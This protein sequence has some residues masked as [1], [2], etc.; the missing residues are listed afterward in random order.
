MAIL[1]DF[2]LD[3]IDVDWE[4]PQDDAQA[5]NFVLL[6]QE[7]RRQL[8]VYDHSIG[9]GY[10]SLLT[11]AAP[12]GASN[13]SKLKI[14]EMDAYLDFWNL[15]AYDFAG[16]WDSVSGHQA[17]IYPSQT[18]PS[19]TPFSA[20]AAINAYIAG[21]VR[22]DKLILGLPLYGRAF[23]NTEGLGKPFSGVGQGSWE[24]GV[25]DYKALPHAGATETFDP[26]TIASYSYDPTSKKLV[27][28]DN[29]QA[30]KTKAEYIKSKGLGGAMW[31]ETSGDKKPAEGG[32]LIQAVVDS[33][34]GKGA[35]DS[36]PN[37]LNF[38]Q[39]RYEN[40]R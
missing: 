17:N 9:G 16:S 3:G 14:R 37:N 40:I 21:G 8:D 19:S 13:Y 35:L 5:Q 20:D 39:S 2:G 7:C 32:S 25:W 6:L 23:E 27:S 15:M 26:A 36:S 12:C 34:G 29:V 31:W 1:K 4:Y 30:Q 33:F 22:P 11:I 18:N 24:N 28:Y 38:P 10:H